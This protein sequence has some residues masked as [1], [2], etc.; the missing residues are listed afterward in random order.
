MSVRQH[1]AVL[2]FQ[3]PSLFRPFAPAA[4]SRQIILFVDWKSQ[5][6]R[7]L[8]QINTKLNREKINIDM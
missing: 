2:F 6:F 8:K 4:R 1:E 3:L 5:S 7:N